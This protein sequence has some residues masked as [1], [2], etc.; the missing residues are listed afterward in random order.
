MTVI[1]EKAA[2]ALKGAIA[3]QGKHKGMLKARAPKADTLAFA[4]WHGAMLCCNPYK[5]SVSA[6]FWMTPEQKDIW[7]EIINVFDTWPQLRLADRDRLALESL[8]VW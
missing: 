2:L 5:A 1:S 3:S 7:K 8:G 6:A 4:A